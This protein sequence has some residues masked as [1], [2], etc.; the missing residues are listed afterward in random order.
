M[1][2]GMT[3]LAGVF[4]FVCMGMFVCAWAEQPD[5]QPGFRIQDGAGDLKVNLYSNM[6]AT[7]WNNDGAKDLLVSQIYYGWLWLYLNQG[8]NLNPEFDGGVLVESDGS[9]IEVTWG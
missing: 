1:K 2:A 4:V 5:L 7:D 8:T 9:P 3:A 6:T